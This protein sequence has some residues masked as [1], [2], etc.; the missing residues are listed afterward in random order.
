MTHWWLCG[1]FAAISPCAQTIYVDP[2]GKESYVHRDRV[3]GSTVDV[4]SKRRKY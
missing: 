3:L 4:S 2:A 1:A